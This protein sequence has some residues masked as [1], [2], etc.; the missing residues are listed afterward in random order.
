MKE[1][2]INHKQYFFNLAKI[3]ILMMS[4]ILVMIYL[5]NSDA[6]FD[7]IE[8][9]GKYIGIPVG[10]ALL[11]WFMAIYLK[12]RKEYIALH[13]SALTLNGNT[14]P[15]HD[16]KRVYQSITYIGPIKAHCPAIIIE[17]HHGKKWEYVSYFAVNQ[18]DFDA[19][20]TTLKKSVSS[21]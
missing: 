1:L 13:E 4:A 7:P 3:G 16:V 8:W 18:K 10:I 17:T 11:V 6:Y 5:P 21:K 2:R 15:L 14:I 19:F 12:A 20:V 9:M